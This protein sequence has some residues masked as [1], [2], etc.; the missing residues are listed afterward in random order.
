MDSGE[1]IYKELVHERASLWYVSDEYGMKIMVKAPSNTLKALINRCKVELL[2]GKDHKRKNPIFHTGIRIYDDP[3]HYVNLTGPHRYEEE[4]AA[5]E[6]IMNLS[7]TPLQVYDELNICVATAEVAFAVSDQLKVLNFLGNTSSLHTGEFDEEMR[8]SQDCFDFTLDPKCKTE[9]TYSIQSL[10]VEVKPCSW[11]IIKTTVAGVQDV[12]SIHLG[13]KDEGSVFE[14]QIW[15]SLEYLFNYK[16]F[17]SPA[18]AI[19]KGTRE[20]TDV[21]AYSD[22]GIFLIEAKAMGIFN[23]ATDKTMEKKVSTLQKQVVKAIDQ[24]VGAAKKIR[25]GEKIFDKKGNLITFNQTFVPHCIVLVSELLPFGDWKPIVTEMTKAMCSKDL[26]LFMHLMDLKEFMQYVGMAQSNPD[27][28]DDLLLHRVDHL[29]EHQTVY[30][31]IKQG[32]APTPGT[33]S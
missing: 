29:V 10:A 13:D 18:C 3:I 24:L 12:N 25:E 1:R 21:M 23:V 16:V 27:R 6:K 5:V 7:S 33:K 28:F 9:R 30:L 20:V 31:Q 2:F 26:P 15:A 22:Y 4:H 17:K 11:N 32:V 14:N 19:L 8:H